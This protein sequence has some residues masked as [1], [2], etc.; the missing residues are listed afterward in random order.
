MKTRPPLPPAYQ[1]IYEAHYRENRDGASAAAGIAQRLEAWM[2]RAVASDARAANPGPTLEIG[3]GTLNQL[4]YEPHT[5]PYDIVEPFDALYRDRPDLDRVRRVYADVGRIPQTERYVRI[6]SIATFEH[7][8]DLRGMVQ[9]CVQLLAPGGKLRVAI[10][11][12]GH[13]PWT[14]AWRI[15]TGLEFR[16]RYGLD[17]AVLMRHEHLNTADEIASELRAA[18]RSVDERWFGLSRILSLY[19]VLIAAEPT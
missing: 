16:M 3:A 1:A 8:T 14:L 4:A 5:K 9:A 7:L 10:P 6:T 12:E 18:F 15:G 13:W 19:R 11:N 17:Y 2:H